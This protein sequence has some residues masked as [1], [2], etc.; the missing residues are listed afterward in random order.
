MVDVNKLMSSLSSSGIAKGFLGGMAGGA[1][2]SSLMGKRGGK[3][4]KKL[5]KVGGVAAVGTLAWK[6]YQHYKG[7][8]SLADERVTGC[9]TAARSMVQSEL[10]AGVQKNPQPGF[11]PNFRSGFQSGFQPEV[12]SS[13]AVLEP[14][15]KPGNFNHIEQQQLVDLSDPACE[16]SQ[17]LFIVKTMVSAAMADGH[18]N[19][20]E[21]KNILSKIEELGL[22]AEEKA[23]VFNEIKSP[24]PL[25]TVIEKS[26]SAELS[27]EVYTASV[28]AIDE[29]REEGRHYLQ[30]LAY[31]LE[32]PGGLVEAIHSQVN[33]TSVV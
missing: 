14:A 6:A 22:G 11:Q 16:S 5:I 25:E 24:M 28:L 30:Q 32:L 8:Q 23:I 19:T 18:I 13:E 2:T 20:K 15:K 10:N 1:V 12:P 3:T 4:V 26:H 33:S 21:Y 17:A 7:N 29:S 27:I 31:G 9:E